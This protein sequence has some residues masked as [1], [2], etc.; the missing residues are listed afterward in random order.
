LR[1]AAA[2]LTIGGV[3]HTEPAVQRPALLLGVPRGRSCST[4]STCRSRKSRCEGAGIVN[5]PEPKGDGGLVC[6]VR[7]FFAG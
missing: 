2:L 6:A 1:S 3:D 7:Q 4:P 5:P